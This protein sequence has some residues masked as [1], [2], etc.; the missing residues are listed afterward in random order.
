L[1]GSWFLPLFFLSLVNNKQTTVMDNYEVQLYKEGQG[2]TNTYLVNKKDCT[3]GL[4]INA[5]TPEGAVER[6]KKFMK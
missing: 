5:Y 6:Y 3:V 4:Y 2:Y 1:G